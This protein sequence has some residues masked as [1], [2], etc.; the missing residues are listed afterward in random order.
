M[1]SAG[2]HEELET[3]LRQTHTQYNS[4]THTLHTLINM[5]FDYTLKAEQADNVAPQQ[6]DTTPSGDQLKA[7]EACLAE[8]SLF[9]QYSTE[10]C[11]T[12]Q[13]GECAEMIKAYLECM[14][15]AAAKE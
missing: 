8:P 15:G 12:V 1:G 3:Q 11:S 4:N 7:Q 6:G 14:E 10:E 13:G 2:L 9:I 5:P